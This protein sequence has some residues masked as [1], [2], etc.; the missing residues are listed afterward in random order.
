MIF[1]YS[2]IYPNL[3][4]EYWRI[5]LSIFAIFTGISFILS[6]M[7]KPGYLKKKAEGEFLLLLTKFDPKS[8][9][10]FCEVV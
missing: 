2:V 8:L 6:W 1:L 4:D 3:K 7:V 9:C 5:S 10:P